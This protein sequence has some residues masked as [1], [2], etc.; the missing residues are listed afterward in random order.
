MKK[1]KGIHPSFAVTPQTTKVMATVL[2]KCLVKM[3][4]ELNLYIKIT[5]FGSWPRRERG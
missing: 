4:N 5:R 3:E 2:D 1:G